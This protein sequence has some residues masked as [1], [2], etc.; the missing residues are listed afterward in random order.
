MTTQATVQG[1][2]R[3]D[4]VK[5]A[6]GYYQ[7][8]GIQVRPS[9]PGTKRIVLKR[10][11]RPRRLTR[12]RISGL[13]SR[14]RLFG[15]CGVWGIGSRN[16]TDVEAETPLGARALELWVSASPISW[17]SP[18]NVASHR[19]IRVA[20]TPARIKSRKLTGPRGRV[21]IELR[22]DGAQSILPPSWHP[23]GE[24]YRF[25]TYELGKPIPELPYDD[26]L[27]AC[28]EA[29]VATLIAEQYPQ[30]KADRTRHQMALALAGV[31][32]RSGR[33]LD[34]CL[35]FTIRL[36]ELAGDDEVEDRISCVHSTFEARQAGQRTT[37][38]PTLGEYLDPDVVRAIVKLL[39]VPGRTVEEVPPPA[40]PPFQTTTF[41]GP[42]DISNRPGQKIGRT[43]SSQPPTSSIIG[44]RLSKVTSRQ[45]E[46]LWRGWIPLR[47]IA[48]VDGDPDLGKSTMSLDLAARVTTGN[49]MPDQSRS[50]LQEPAGVVIL[51]AEDDLDDTVRPRADA[52][53]ADVDRIYCLQGK[54]GEYGERAVTLADIEEIRQAIAEVG[55]KLVIID[56]L[57]AYFPLTTDSYKDQHARSILAPLKK[58]AADTG[59]AVLV[60]RHLNKSGGPNPLYRGGVRSG[61]SE[62]SGRA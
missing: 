4:A 18:E 40:E 9:D 24:P 38:I 46:W 12:W 10:W 61:S 34:A 17:G 42:N 22:A 29:T 36:V 35:G 44:T 26:L 59:V 15:V 5:V 41:V 58:L 21:V 55:A 30:L 2:S 11:P 37:G 23:C 51:T 25:S 39:H 56:P 48:V 43:R 13:F 50:D 6:G 20:G 32:L 28:E 49:P 1:L 19:L 33:G 14:G 54:R 7:D 60:V 62:P 3:E 47:K 16:L 45:V 57:M 8:L 27:R 52:L 53:G 31:L